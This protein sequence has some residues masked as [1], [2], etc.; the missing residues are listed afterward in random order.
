M[1]DP[2]A[3]PP[4][5]HTHTHTLTPTHPHTHPSRTSIPEPLSLN[6][7]PS[8]HISCA[9]NPYPDALQA[10]SVCVKALKTLKNIQDEIESEE[11]AKS[12]APEV[13]FAALLETV[14]ATVPAAPVTDAT[15]QIFGEYLST[16]ISSMINDLLFDEFEWKFIAVPFL[17]IP[18]S[19]PLE[20]SALTLSSPYPFSPSLPYPT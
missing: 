1:S 14:S 4:L 3:R 19:G 2:E 11:A 5:S 6:P 12:M 13:C 17:A 15:F 18:A 20:P 8:A 9:L 10:R 7:E 16:L